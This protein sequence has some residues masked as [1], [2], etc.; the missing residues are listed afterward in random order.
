[1]P[2]YFYGEDTYAARQALS[3]LAAKLSAK[4]VFLD[5]SDVDQTSLLSRL[6]NGSAGLFGKQLFVLR[7]PSLMPAAIQE[8]LV[9]LMKNKRAYEYVLWDRGGTDKRSALFKA[10]KPYA[11]EFAPLPDHQLAMWLKERAV[12]LGGELE[13]VAAQE[14]VTRAGRDRWHLEQ[15]LQK[16][17]LNTARIELE[18]VRKQVVA[19]DPTELIFA[20]TDALVSRNRARAMTALERLLAAGEHE[21]ALLGFVAS[22]LRMLALIHKG[23]RSGQSAEAIAKQYGLHPYPV[24]KN[25]MAAK[26]FSSAQL[27]DMYTRVLATDFAVKQGT[28]DPRTGLTMLI[29]SLL[30][31]VTVPMKTPAR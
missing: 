4:L 6:E 24:Q 28:I 8:S 17:L 13:T 16:L 15:E 2:H 11:Q 23:V 5:R 29:L 27:L 31:T 1:M 18:D 10:A 30:D 26:G 21:I 9:E 19:S 3:D 25:M 12:N 20:L 14:F 22:Q 7:D